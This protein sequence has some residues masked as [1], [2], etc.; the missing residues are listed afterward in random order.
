MGHDMLEVNIF[1]IYQC[2]SRP[3]ECVEPMVCEGNTKVGQNRPQTISDGCINDW[4]ERWVLVIKEVR[5]RGKGSRIHQP[6]NGLYRAQRSIS[7][8]R[9]LD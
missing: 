2:G 1:I 6:L 4:V 5:G 7:E 9:G 3:A 8:E